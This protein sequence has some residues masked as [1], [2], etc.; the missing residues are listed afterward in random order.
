MPNIVA[1]A[2]AFPPHYYSQET[3]SRELQQIWAEHGVRPERAERLHRA[4]SVEG[5]HIAVPKEE[6]YDLVGWETPNAIFTEAA[7]ELGQRVLEALFEDSPLGTEDITQLIFASTT[8]LAIPTIDARLMNRMSFR[9]DL[10]RLPVYGLGCVA[11]A[12]G[13]ARLA[14]Y[15][16]GHPDEAAV[17]LC[18]EFCS[19]TIQTHDVSVAN[20]IACGLFGDGGAAVLMVGDDHPSAATASPRVVAS[21]SIFFPEAE[22]YMGWI[23][24][25]AGM[26]LVLSPEVPRA[27][28]RALRKPVVEL[29]EEHG[30]RLADVDR[31]VCH[32]GGPRVIDAIEQALDLNGSTLD[33]SR[34][35]LQRIGNISSAS[36]LVLLDE[37]V[38]SGEVEKGAYGVMMA[39][40]P[41]FSAELVLLQW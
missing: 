1:T 20:Q 5:R 15:L 19:L 35:V 6:Y 26:E 8:G 41:G 21:R 24:R 4:T 9:N 18:M 22:D 23:V 2:A 34:A 17:L 12:A 31:W 13:V 10:K 30:L 3:I 40:G 11:G 16:H 37:V 14:D 28:K 38:R 39:M 33:P 7:L 36:V 25:E 27:V 32:P 29:L